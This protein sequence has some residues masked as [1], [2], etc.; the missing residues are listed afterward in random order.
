MIGEGSFGKG[1]VQTLI[2]LDR[3]GGSEKAR[4]G[5]LK[6]TVAQFFRINGGTTQLRGVTPDIKLPAMSDTDNFGESSYDNALPWVAIKPAPFT[7]TGDM[8]EIVPLLDKKHEVRVAKDKDFQY[9]QDDIAL[10]V[11]QRKENQLSL[12]ETVRRKERDAQEARTR[13]REKRLIA[14]ISNPADD[15]VV[16]QDPKD[17]LKGAKAAAKTAKQ[18]AAVK[19]AL[20]TDDGLQGDERALS[21]ELDAESAAKSAKDVLL[22]ETVRILADEVALIKGDTRL[23]AKV[24][25]YGADTKATPVAATK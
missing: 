22:N 19:G 6:M 11:K 25:P 24:L 7:P 1:T 3:F 20:R 23:A 9:L 2:N 18:I 21:A 17:V 16:I 14:Q 15:L 10:V 8:K 4:L 13:A 5:E 12:N